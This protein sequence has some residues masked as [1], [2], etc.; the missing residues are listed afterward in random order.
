MKYVV[1]EGKAITS[2]KGVLGEGA[3]ITAQDLH[4]EGADKID[5]LVRK[6]C[7]EAV[8]VTASKKSTNKN[9][10]KA[11]SGK[12]DVGEETKADSGKDDVGEETKADSGKDK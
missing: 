9:K 3:E 5:R 12:D 8:E 10:T 4:G 6:G 1:K 2:K 11:D 7:I